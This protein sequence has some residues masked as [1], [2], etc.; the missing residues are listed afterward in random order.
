MVKKKV[1]LVAYGGGHVASLVP[2]LPCLEN[3]GFEVV[4]LALTTAGAFLSRK[5]VRYLSFRNLPEAS[6]KN[7]LQEGER[8]AEKI[9]ANTAVNLEETLAYLGLNYKYLVLSHGWREAEKIYNQHGRAAFLPV[10]LFKRWFYDIRPD[11]VIATNA[12]RSEKASILAA[13][14]LGIPSICVVDLFAVREMKWIVKD[15]FATRVCVAN[16]AIRDQFIKAGCNPN[17]VIATGNPAFEGILSSAVRREGEL[18]KTRMGL[19]AEFINI[20][21]ASQVEPEVHPFN[22]RK[23]D[24]NLPVIIEKKLRELV[25]KNQRFKLVL[26][27]HA[28]ETRE[29]LSSGQRIIIADQSVPLHPLLHAIDI[30]VTATS[31]VGYEAFLIG[32]YVITIDCSVFS[33]DVPYSKVGISKGV[34][35]P[36]ELEDVINKIEGP[37]GL[38]GKEVPVPDA[39]EN[40]EKIVKDMLENSVFT[41]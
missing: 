27:P 35:S 25:E 9:S 19:N 17:K 23:G 20:L 1:V 7:V 28:S 26:R 18:L 38:P 16:N 32:K 22:G 5:G 12:P 21:Y 34:S 37:V 11:L 33:D 3:N 10:E 40:I 36:D 6:D 29:V 30:L 24:P 8:L 2:L 15:D 4:F 39:V 14:A 31:T 41:R 13:R